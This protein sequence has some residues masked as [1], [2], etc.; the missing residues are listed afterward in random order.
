MKRRRLPGLIAAG[1]CFLLA[2]GFRFAVIGYGVMSLTAA[3]A[4][5]CILL[6]LYLPKTLR[7]VLTVLLVVGLAVFI[8]AEIPVVRAAKGTPDTDADYL[9]VL[10]AGVNGSTPSLSMLDR[11]TAAKAY[12]DDHPDCVAVVSGGQGPGEN[13]TEAKAMSD[14]LTAR[15]IAQDHIIPEDRATSTAENLA[16][17]LALIPDARN[18]SIAVCSSEYHLYRAEYLAREL[19]YGLAGVPGRTG[20][21]LLRLNYFIREGFGVVYYRVFGI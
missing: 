5:L 4:G 7:I 3:F 16:F 20:L 1:I 8:S 17:S 21:P 9:I 18:A 6:Y 13:I 14:W 2:I 12:L 10:G 11:L 19:G 15:G